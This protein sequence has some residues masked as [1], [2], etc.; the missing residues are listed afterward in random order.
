VAGLGKRR[1]EMAEKSKQWAF[2]PEMRER[3]FFFL[4]SFSI[5]EFFFFS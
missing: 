3:L 4:K 1:K 2:G 5:S